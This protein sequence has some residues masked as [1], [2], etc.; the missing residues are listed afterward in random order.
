MNLK[1]DKCKKNCGYN[2]IERI[3]DDY[4]FCFNCHNKLKILLY[5]VYREEAE[6]FIKHADK[7]E[8]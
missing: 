8:L 1:C 2:E 5:K 3:V 6:K 7:A 4:Q